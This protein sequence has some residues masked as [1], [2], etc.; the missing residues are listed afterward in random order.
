MKAL[1]SCRNVGKNRCQKTWIIRRKCARLSLVCSSE[2]SWRGC[3]W[4]KG[5]RGSRIVCNVSF[6]KAV[7]FGCSICFLPQMKGWS[8]WLCTVLRAFFV[9]LMKKTFLRALLTLILLMIRRPRNRYIASACLK[10]LRRDTSECG[11]YLLRSV[12]HLHNFF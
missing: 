2:G 8:L 7:L 1:R 10:M 6:Q 9:Y 12:H 11:Q 4:P 5:Y 3:V